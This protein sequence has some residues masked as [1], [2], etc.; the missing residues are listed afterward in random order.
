MGRLGKTISVL[1]TVVGLS[2]MMRVSGVMAAPLLTESQLKDYSQ[3]GVLFYTPCGESSSS[4]GGICGTNRNY[5]GEQVWT[6]AELE[7]IKANEKFYKTAGDQYG[8]PWQAIAAIHKREHN[9]VRS[10]P[11]N[12][13]GVYQFYSAAERAACAGG[14]F[15]PGKVS[16]EQ[17][18]IQTNCLAKRLKEAYGKGLDLNT[19]DGL[20]RLFYNYNSGNNGSAAYNAQARKL[21]FSAEE[22]ERGEG[23]PY[24][25]NRYD[26]KREPS[27]TWGQI[28]TDGGG[29]V[30]PANNDFGAFVY[31]KA[32]TCGEGGGVACGS[33][34]QG[35]MNLNS[36]A[37]CLA[38][39]AET[40]DAKTDYPGGSGSEAFN[41]AH[42]KVT[43]G[44]SDA[45]AARGASCD[46][47]VAT[48][49]RWAGYDKDYPLG[50]VMTQYAWARNHPEL[51]EVIDWDGDQSKVQ[52]GD[53][54]WENGG[55]HTYI[56]MQDESGKNWIASASHCDY[57]G[58]IREWRNPRLPAKI[59]RAKSAHNSA[60]GSG[61]AGCDVC[62]GQ[63]SNGKLVQGGFQSVKE[64]EESVMKEYKGLNNAQALAKYH[65]TVGCGGVLIRNC[66]SFV[67][68]FVNKYTTKEWVGAT[69][70]GSETADVL[71]QKYD[72]P[73]G[74]TP[75][76]Y[77][78]F[79]VEGG[80]TMC[81]NKRCGHTGVV[82]GINVASNKIIIGEAGCGSPVSWIGAHE[83]DLTEYNNG[84]YKYTYLDGILKSGGLSGEQ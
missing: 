50:N 62:A 24:V 72:L 16:D 77:A 78:V 57:F 53:V 55:G 1:L 15:T 18:Q 49:V 4:S 37:A 12:G 66:P 76:A 17:F 60:G 69:G 20:K 73:T 58:K 33:C 42:K 40:E 83:Y 13:Q 68:Y 54:I 5:A 3:N 56:V 65:I 23:S 27:S 43:P 28:K 39:P 52:A 30:Y 7:A 79:S 45:C 9:L 81:G 10:N 47:F 21:G 14:V 61:A 46:M 70:N 63:N 32:I 75:K 36:T 29:I 51:W 48:V 35:N 38:W 25:M 82:L 26:A 44:S 19:D 80:A 11:A 31:Y 74:T 34:D 2:L 67:K 64:A 41:D 8:V 84:S 71:A 6:D 22:A 59:I